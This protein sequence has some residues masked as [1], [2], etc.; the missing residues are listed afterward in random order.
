MEQPQ[1]G[2]MPRYYAIAVGEV[3]PDFV[4]SAI[5]R[6]LTEKHGKPIN[7][8]HCGILVE[9]DYETT[10]WDATGRGFEPCTLNEALGNG[11]AVLRHKVELDVMNAAMALGWLRGNRGRWYA[12][13]QYVL[14]FMP[15]WLRHAMSWILP[16]FIKKLFS[17]GRAF[18]VC[19]EAARKHWT[20]SCA[21]TWPTPM[22]Y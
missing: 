17:N 1:T 15:K 19:S 13:A 9:G 5:Q 8:S 6:Y 10:V 4:S 22:T 18:Q 11:K 14:F 7:W 20:T 3:K 12:H 21:T 16:G 2:T